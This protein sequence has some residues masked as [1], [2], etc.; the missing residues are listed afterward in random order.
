[1]MSRQNAQGPD[2]G[3]VQSQTVRVTLAEGTSVLIRPIVPDDKAHLEAGFERLSAESRYLRFHHAISRLSQDELR[4]LTEIDYHDQFAWVAFVSDQ[5]GIW[6]IGVARYFRLSP[7]SDKAEAAVAV[8]DDYQGRG[9]GTMLLAMLARTAREHDI[10]S[11]IA[12]VQPVNSRVVRLARMAG[13]AFSHED[14]MLRFEIPL[15][16]SNAGIGAVLR[17]AAATEIVV[18]PGVSDQ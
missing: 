7:S 10:R 13:A 12:Y 16:E 6:L 4:Y 3:W 14:G 9:L 2:P 5:T 17:A 18:T 11:F 15:D 1:M 8:I